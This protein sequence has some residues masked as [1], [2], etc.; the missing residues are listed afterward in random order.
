[1]AVYKFTRAM[2]ANEPIDVFNHGR[3]RRDFTYIDD[4]IA[5]IVAAERRVSE[6]GNGDK[7]PVLCRLYNL[8]NN[9]PVELMELIST[10]EESLGV[11]ARLRFHAM[12]P[13]DVRETYAEIEAATHDLSFRPR[14]T[15]RQ[16]ITR[17]VE[18][19]REYHGVTRGR[20]RRAACR[21]NDC[22]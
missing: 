20:K 14:T 16:G 9:R 2:L 19:Y 17:F 6:A 5:G 13:G 11:K 21:P 8:G 22:H 7:S 4:V 10:L 15:L 18:W 3:M 12:Q 1:M